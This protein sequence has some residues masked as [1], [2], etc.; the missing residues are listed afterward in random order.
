M[1][2][3]FEMNRLSNSVYKYDQ[4]IPT[5]GCYQCCLQCTGCVGGCLQTYLPC[6]AWLCCACTCKAYKQ[7]DQGSWGVVRKFGKHEKV[8]EAGLHYL[9]P[10]TETMS[11]VTKTR[12]VI[13][14]ERQ[15]CIIDSNVFFHVVDPYTFEYTTNG[16]VKNLVSQLVY[17]QLRLIIGRYTLQ[18]ILVNKELLGSSVKEVLDENATKWGIVIEMVN[19]KDIRMSKSLTEALSAKTTAE[20]YAESKMISARADV[21]SAKMMREAADILNSETAIQFRMLDTYKQIAQSQNAKIIFLP[22][23]SDSS[24][25]R[26]MIAVES[27]S[28]Q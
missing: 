21:E 22:P 14:L 25:V 15:T 13:D 5:E 3:N 23:L 26:N 24:L 2:N 10:N 9:N 18:E 27:S 4:E 17:A 19:V 20:K 1:I 16:K 12:S 6:F 7:V 8:L 11:V 28:N